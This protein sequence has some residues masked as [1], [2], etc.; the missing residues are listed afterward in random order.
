MN[1]ENIAIIE[2]SGIFP[3][4]ENEDIF[5]SNLL[6]GYVAV[7]DLLNPEYG[8]KSDFDLSPHFSVDRSA[9]DMT[10]CRWASFLDRDLLMKYAQDN[11]LSL[12]R[13]TLSEII[14]HEISSRIFKRQER[15]KLPDNIDLVLGISTVDPTYIKCHQ[16]RAVNEWVSYDLLEAPEY[17]CLKQYYYSTR[18]DKINSEPHSNQIS[19]RFSLE[20]LRDR[21]NLGGSIQIVEAACAASLGAMFVGINRL[22]SGLSEGVLVGSCGLDLNLFMMAGFSK[23]G[24]ESPDIT[25]PFSKAAAGMNP[26]EAA[27]LFL[28][29]PENE[30]IKRKLP[31]KGIILSCEGSSDGALGGLVE[32]TEAGQISVYQRA[33]KHLDS[34]LIDYLETHGTGTAVGDKTEISS[35]SHFF[36]EG[37]IIGGSKA[38]VAHTMCAAGTVSLIKALKIMETK[39]IPP[40]PQK[41]EWMDLKGLKIVEDNPM[42]IKTF[43]NKV[44]LRIGISAFGFGG[45]N[46]HLVLGE[47]NDLNNSKEDNSKIKNSRIV[48]VGEHIVPMNLVADYFKMSGHRIPPITLPHLDNTIIGAIVATEQLFQK[49]QIRLSDDARIEVGVIST[50]DSIL[51]VSRKWVEKEALLDV[52]RRLPD[53]VPSALEIKKMI[54]EKIKCYS[55]LTEDSLPGALNNLISGKVTKAFDLRGP[56]FNLN[57]ERAS[58]GS[59][60]ESACSIIRNTGGAY[61]VTSVI[62]E[63]SADGSKIN[64]DAVAVY[65]I[66]DLDFALKHNLPIKKEIGKISRRRLAINERRNYPNDPIPWG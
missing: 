30:A 28:L 64:R 3:D 63:L 16:R 19:F 54:N 62:E 47:K 55:E 7:K 11:H 25:V 24:V 59:A 43:K 41:G 49:L 57:D 2:Y 53:K 20:S 61:V 26:G 21:F 31:I 50:S 5:F 42:P 58:L 34:H 45:S 22:R 23:I 60:I 18:L 46:F 12:D 38:N 15:S 35:I 8:S 4:A 56:N 39:L 66:S 14:L 52:L 51:D 6:K 13:S 48:L 44:G 33:Y 27:G 40:Q 36:G 29:L 17:S 65:F 32:P 1:K 9:P 37:L 10:Y